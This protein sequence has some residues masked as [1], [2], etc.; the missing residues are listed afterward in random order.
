MEIYSFVLYLTGMLISAYY[1]DELIAL[2]VNRKYKK[3]WNTIIYTMLILIQVY[4]GDYLLKSYKF[5]YVYFYIANWVFIYLLYKGTTLKKALAYIE[6]VSA[7]VFTELIGA[8]VIIGIMGS[9]A[10]DIMRL[11]DMRIFINFICAMALIIVVYI[12][13]FIQKKIKFRIS[14]SK[15]GPIIMVF[16]SQIIVGSIYNLILFDIGTNVSNLFLFYIFVVLM[17]DLWLLRSMSLLEIKEDTEGKIKN[18]EKETELVAEYYSELYENINNLENIKSE[19]NA[20]LKN[21]YS[22]TGKISEFQEIREVDIE[23]KASEIIKS[24]KSNVLVNNIISN[25]KSQLDLLNVQYKIEVDVPE[26]ISMDY[27]DLSSILIN[28]F[29]NAIEAIEVYVNELNEGKSVKNKE[30]YFLEGIVYVNE[31]EIKIEVKNVKSNK[32]K[33][34]LLDDKYITSKKDKSIHGYGM[35]IIKR[36]VEKYN[37]NMEVEYTNNSFKNSVICNCSES[38]RV[39]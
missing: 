37:G 3:H 13:M 21:I 9:G 27:S 4:L 6:V 38:S 39:G 12:Y 5:K 26:I 7:V 20:E 10:E 19:Y 14:A 23:N 31:K 30:K 35:Q 18:F 15:L 24:N 36:T 22:I 29:G 2:V 34:R 8:Q 28:M 32:Q 25:I 33:V 1:T 17:I 16:L 11:T